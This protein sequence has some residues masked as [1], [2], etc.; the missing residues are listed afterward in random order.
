MPHDEGE[1]MSTANQLHVSQEIDPNAVEASIQESRWKPG[2][3][4]WLIITCC[5]IIAIVVALDATIL[6]PLLPVSMTQF[7][8]KDVQTDCKKGLSQS[9]GGTAVDT[10][11]TGTA[12]LVPCAVFQPFIT[13]LSDLFGR[14]PLLFLSLLL[15]TVGTLVCCLANGFPQLLTGRVA[16]GIG[17][18]GSMSGCYVVLSDI[19]PLRQR[20]LYLA[21]IS[22]AGALGTITGPLIGG[23]F[24]EYSTWRW[25]FYINFPFCGVGLAMVF[26]S[27]KLQ[28]EQTPL[29]DRFRRIDF[30]GA[31]L[32]IAST[33]SLLIGLTW[34]GTE[35]PW[36]SWHTLVP[37]IVGAIGLVASFYWENSV[38]SQPFLRVQLFKS[39]SA[40]AA[41]ICIFLQG[42]MLFCE[43]YYIP[44]YLE[45]VKSLSPTLA[46]V[47]LM[48]ISAVVLPTSA[49]TGALISRYGHFRWAIW[50]GWLA[51][52]IATSLLLLLNISIKTYGWVLIFAAVGVGHGF[53]FS[54]LSVC[55]QAFADPADTGYA[56]GLYTFMRTF[57]MCIGV[58]IGGTVFQNRFTYYTR[59]LDLPDGLSTNAEVLVSA[60]QEISIPSHLRES[61]DVAY[62]KSFQDLVKVLIGMAALGVLASL[63]LK[64]ATMDRQ[65][66]SKHLLD[67]IK[68]DNEKCS[69][70]AS[71]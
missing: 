15:F 42:L 68:P 31:T 43:L 10:F 13:S 49:V 38:A 39:T 11:W 64:S 6:V 58:P 36:D 59:G 29:K 21:M 69:D 35:F 22:L 7:E 16:Q 37:I 14:R 52:I 65:L 70:S 40:I 48:P 9:L 20:P 57:G 51:T 26:F 8:N 27:L 25:A 46:G 50:S 63:F 66:E 24:E 60:L 62:A 23:L 45:S 41:Y 5:C 17:G 71:V 28:T 2:H 12:Y 47:G 61:L 33:C 32:F 53:N 56:A 1:A 44:I 67:K 30:A 4:E 55:V 18:A 54:S 19:I 34:G 3:R